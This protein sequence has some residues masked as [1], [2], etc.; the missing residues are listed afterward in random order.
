MSSSAKVAESPNPQSGA[1]II[2]AMWFTVIVAGIV[3][4]GTLY[5]ES[6]RRQ[7]RN[8]FI[9]KAQA[10]QIARSGLTE[11][12]SW[13][14]RQTSQPVMGFAPQLDPLATPPVLDTI[15]PDIGLVREFQISGKQWARYEVWKV[16][17]ADP[18]PTRLAW[19]QQMQCEDISSARLAAAAGSIW[20]LRSLGY[21]YNLED[22]SK[23][24]NEAPN[25]IIGRE[26]LET[27]VQR[28]SINLPGEAAVNV[29]DGNSCHINTN[30]RIIGGT[31][32]GIYYP[33]GSGTPTTGP[34]S[35]NRVTGT[36]ALSTA[37]GYDDS[38][39]AVFGVGIDDLRS[40]ADM[41]VT[42]PSEFP[43]P[44]SNNALVIVDAT[45][46]MQWDSAIPLLGSGIV[47]VLGNA[48]LN[49][50]SLSN[51]SGLLYID[52]NFTMRDPAEIRGAVMCT[53]NMTVQGNPD[54][55]TI[56]FDE[57]VLNNLRMD[58][59]NYQRSNTLLIPF[60]RNE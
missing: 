42:D 19:R 14:R 24:F 5:L 17:D 27:E 22:P 21:V 23:A 45:S 3:L 37:V 43:S 34:A 41:I 46:T 35:A 51:F 55:A 60:R 56:L 6:H 16:W 54:Y 52:G 40:M 29:G 1:A 8:S 50:G 47:I 7:T 18:D 48:N 10:V 59:G 11:A 44:V 15:D 2:V 31:A 26:L 32:G 12:L 53:G 13:M 33:A 49:S 58:F 30:G 39:E 9:A 36:P 25:S 38:F 28:L 57:D 4:T 20:R